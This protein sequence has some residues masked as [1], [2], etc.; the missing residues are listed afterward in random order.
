MWAL[1]GEMFVLDATIEDPSFIM[2]HNTRLDYHR[3]CANCHKFAMSTSD[4]CADCFDLDEG[5]IVSKDFKDRCD[6]ERREMEEQEV[7]KEFSGTI[8][9]FEDKE[10]DFSLT[11]VWSGFRVE[12]EDESDQYEK[13]IDRDEYIEYRH[14]RGVMEL[15]RWEK[16]VRSQPCAYQRTIYPY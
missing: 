5:G 11:C 10:Y 2:A 3:E 15:S 4:R 16:E 12:E 7:D 1:Y 14:D 6:K 9:T 13:G 8:C